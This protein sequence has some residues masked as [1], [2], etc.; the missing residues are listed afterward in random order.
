M[1]CRCEK[2]S[3]PRRGVVHRYEASLGGRNAERPGLVL[4]PK[5]RREQR[6]ENPGTVTP[7]SR[8]KP[9]S[10]FGVGEGIAS[11]RHNRRQ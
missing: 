10:S 11:V 4:G 1:P 8:R 7:P 6:P 2:P 3:H 9:Y 5:V